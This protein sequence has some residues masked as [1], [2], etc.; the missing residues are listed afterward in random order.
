[1][2]AAVLP[3]CCG[4]FHRSAACC[5]HDSCL[6]AAVVLRFWFA[7]RNGFRTRSPVFANGSSMSSRSMESRR[8]SIHSRCRRTAEASFD[9][10]AQCASARRAS[11]SSRAPHESSLASHSSKFGKSKPKSAQPTPNRSASKSSQVNPWIVGSASVPRARL[12]FGNVVMTCAL[13]K[14]RRGNGR[15]PTDRPSHGM[16][17]VT[18]RSGA[19]TCHWLFAMR[20]PRGRI[21]ALGV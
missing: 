4:R 5:C 7:F 6:V 11:S 3:A 16:C 2:S 14:S 20:R 21:R 18:R 10:I 13:K 9:R 1:M 8:S 19:H 12:H 17:D 15:R